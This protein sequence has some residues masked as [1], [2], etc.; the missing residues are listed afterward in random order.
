VT[1]VIQVGGKKRATVD[2]APT[3]AE[4][5]LKGEV[6]KAMSGTSY[7]VT[8]SSRFITVFNPGTKVPRLV[9][10]LPG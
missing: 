7:N 6:I 8:E 9:N 4:D 2:V 1:V 5:E 10:V 3:I